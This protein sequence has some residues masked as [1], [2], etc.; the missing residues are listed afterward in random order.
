MA[1]GFKQHLRKTTSLL[2]LLTSLCLP[3]PVDANP[4]ASELIYLLENYPSILSKASLS[5]ATREDVNAA[6]G[7]TLPS[8]SLTGDTGYQHTDKPGKNDFRIQGGLSATYNLFDG[9]FSVFEIKSSQILH[10]SAL[11]D[12]DGTKQLILFQGIQ[13]YL[14]LV[15][16]NKMVEISQTNVQ[17]VEKIKKFIHDESNVGRMS[18]A[19]LL[20]ARARLA[21]AQEALTAYQG[22]L[23]QGQNRY[24]HLFQRVPTKD[25]LQEPLAP[26]EVVPESLEEALRVAR[27]HNPT[28]KGA[29]LLAEAASARVGVTEAALYPRVDLEASADSKYNVDGVDGNENEGSVLLKLNWKLFDGNRVKSQTRAAALRHNAAMMDLRY[30]HLT[31]EEQVRNSFNV[32][33]T[34]QRRFRTLQEAQS[35][36]KEAFG[37]R[38]EMMKS[39][40]ATIINVLDSALE[41]LNVRIALTSADFNHRL[42]VYQ[43]LLATGQLTQDSLSQLVLEGKAQPAIMDD[44]QLIQQLLDGKALPN[45]TD[46]PISGAAQLDEMALRALTQEDVTKASPE[47]YNDM[48]AFEAAHGAPYSDELAP[49]PAA[50][51]NAPDFSQEIVESGY[52]LVLGSFSEPTYAQER[53]IVAGIDSAFTKDVDVNGTTYQRVLVG[54]MSQEAAQ[55]AKTTAKERGIIDSWVLHEQ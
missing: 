43:L 55:E 19:D 16:Q 46:E 50:G 10:Q 37:A 48:S 40:K 54:P 49:E 52:Y 39:G 20:Q 44:T 3:R 22:S 38:H 1:M 35:I 31:I 47:G 30:K 51:G 36:A 11:V 23:R 53:M 12:L 8:V 17:L 6:M 15:L 2:V 7:L 32:I 14:N 28:L 29:G 34:E 26:S 24:F 41:L 5:D 42:A 18:Q 9:N 13:A 4:L 25:N 27:K 45:R 21:Q 33:E